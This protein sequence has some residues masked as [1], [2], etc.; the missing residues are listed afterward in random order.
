MVEKTSKDF[1]IPGTVFTTVTVNRNW[2][3]AVHQDKGDLKA[4]FGV[5][6]VLEHGKYTGGI[7]VFPKYGVGVD[8]RERDICFA[9]VHQWHGNTP[10]KGIPDAHERISC[11]FY[12]RENM[13]YCGTVEQEREFAKHK[14]KGG[15]V[16]KAK[17]KENSKNE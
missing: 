17:P 10:I 12:Y 14:P 15:T 9:D 8:M 7:L 3:T 1:V 5:M 16:N 2:Q 13:Q 4:G 6:S 11:V